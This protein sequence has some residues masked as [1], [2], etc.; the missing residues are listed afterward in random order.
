M[1]NRSL[2]ETRVGFNLVQA[3]EEQIPAKEA[4][5]TIKAINGQDDVESKTLSKQGRR[6]SYNAINLTY[7]YTSS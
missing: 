3:A 1:G 2:T 6:Q 4:I 5:R 7:C